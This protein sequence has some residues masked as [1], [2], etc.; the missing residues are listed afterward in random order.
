MSHHL[1]QPDPIEFAVRKDVG[2]LAPGAS[3]ANGVV[4]QRTQSIKF[5]DAV[6]A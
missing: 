1:I 4:W 3:E 5:Q 6:P 2:V